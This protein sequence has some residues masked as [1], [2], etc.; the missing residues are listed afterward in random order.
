MNWAQGYTSAYYMSVVD[1][2]T[3]R[4]ID[5]VEITGGSVK[6]MTEGLRESAT[7]DCTEY[8]QGIEQWIRVWMDIEQAGSSEHISLF[9]GLATSPA[10]DFDGI[11]E[12]DALECYSVLKPASDIYLLRGWYAPQGMNGARVIRDLL[13]VTPAPV[14]IAEGAPELSSSIIA[15]DNETRLTM[16][17][18]V[19]TA[20]DWRL[21][22][23]G[24]GEI[25]VEPKPD[26]AAVVFDPHEMDVLETD[27]KVSQDWFEAPNVFVAID[28]DITAIAR[29]NSDTSPLSIENR[30]REVWMQESGVDLANNETIEQYA[31]RRLKEAQQVRKTA[32]YSRRF[33]PDICPGDI[34]GLRYPA[35]SMS[36][37]FIVKN[38]DIELN[39]SAKTTEEIS[40]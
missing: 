4:D 39:Y 26:T 3:W 10:R 6:R 34:V 12:S 16:V 8:P 23:T 25:V 5:R 14:E 27:I 35:Q 11:R 28:D 17:E 36:G 37:D 29:D 24:H 18:K 30:G 9:T 19:L 13:S 1:A 20:I 32:R 33:V 2:A 40:Q 22:I 15:E 31:I 38:Q 7:I 21:R